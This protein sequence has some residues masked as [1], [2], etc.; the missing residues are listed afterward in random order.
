VTGYIIHNGR[1][2]GGCN[3]AAIIQNLC[4]AEKAKKSLDTFF[5]S[6]KADKYDTP[7]N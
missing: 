2:R 3:A 4:Y 6:V 5:P 1:E 7:L